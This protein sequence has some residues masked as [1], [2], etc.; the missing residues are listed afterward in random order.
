MALENHPEKVGWRPLEWAR[1]VGL[2]RATAYNLMRDGRID[3][4][5]FGWTTII[6]TKPSEFLASLR[7]D[8]A[9]Q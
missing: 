2:S 6:V 5:K 9:D 8:G 3:S 4:V 7:D 1:A